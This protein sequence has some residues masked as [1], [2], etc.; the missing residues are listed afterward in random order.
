MG[1]QGSLFCVAVVPLVQPVG[2]V[3]GR[4]MHQGVNVNACTEAGVR[5]KQNQSSVLSD[6]W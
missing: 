3:C 1:S 2:G 6:A 4:V 5:V